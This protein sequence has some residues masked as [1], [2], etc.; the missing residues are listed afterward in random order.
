MKV[1]LD[2]FPKE[3][4]TRNFPR[5]RRGLRPGQLCIGSVKPNK[6]TCQGDSGGPLQLVTNETTCTYHI[7][8]IT[9]LGGA[10]AFGKSLGI[11]TEVAHYIDWIEENVWGTNAL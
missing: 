6:D 9:S 3:N 11:Y 7:V 5:L 8:G 10:C 4:C 2:E 1:Q